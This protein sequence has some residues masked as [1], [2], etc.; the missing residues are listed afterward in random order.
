MV[1]AT[2]GA[3]AAQYGWAWFMLREGVRKVPEDL[4]KGSEPTPLARRA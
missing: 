3:L 1:G 2:T 4:W